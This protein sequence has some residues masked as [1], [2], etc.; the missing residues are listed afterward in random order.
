MQLFS[1]FVLP[2][3]VARTP[4][5]LPEQVE[6]GAPKCVALGLVRSSSRH[7]TEKQFLFFI[8]QSL[9]RHHPPFF[10]LHHPT[11]LYLLV[12][13]EEASL[14]VFHCGN[15]TVKP[16]VHP[17]WQLL[18][19][20]NSSLDGTFPF[21]SCLPRRQKSYGSFWWSPRKAVVVFC[22]AFCSRVAGHG[23][24]SARLLSWAGVPTSPN[25]TGDWPVV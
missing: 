17:K 7:L 3:F 14:V 25:P 8:L 15:N 24:F 23:S 1:S 9:P 16:T 22:L 21:L 18:K 19:N 12:L 10:Q 2:S 13:A 4:K 11:D 6:I 20:N 5:R